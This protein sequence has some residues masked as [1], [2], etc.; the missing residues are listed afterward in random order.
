VDAHG[1]HLLAEMHR[2]G[3]EFKGARLAIQDI[4]RGAQTE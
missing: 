3:V 4:V 2:A 1:R